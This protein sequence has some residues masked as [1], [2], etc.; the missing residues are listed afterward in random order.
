MKG[1]IEKNFFICLVGEVVSRI[2][3]TPLF[4]FRWLF[5]S[6][7]TDKEPPDRMQTTK[8]QREVILQ[9]A[10]D[11]DNFALIEGKRT[12]ASS[13][14]PTGRKALRKAD[15]FQRM[16]A[17]V[18]SAFSNINWMPR[19][20]ETRWKGIKNNYKKIEKESASTG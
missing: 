20:V 16:A 6:M 2:V 7:A 11:P 19:G 17:A 15:G 18:N 1:I 14:P 3:H 9:F 8:A 12:S 10:E 4:H 5:F 13:G